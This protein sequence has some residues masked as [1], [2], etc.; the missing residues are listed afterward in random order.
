M[1]LGWWFPLFVPG[2][3]QAPGDPGL[4]GLVVAVAQPGEQGGVKSG[5]VLAAGGP[6]G[7]GC[8]AEGVAGLPGPGPGCRAGRVS[9]AGVPVQAGEALLDSGEPGVVAEV[10]AV[11]VADQDPAV[12]ARDPGPV[13]SGFVRLPAAPYQMR[14]A[15][16][17]V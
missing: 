10:A 11:V 16:P 7:G 15:P 5:L 2:A 12:A 3:G 1:S 14:S 6:D 9:I 8:R 13:I 17:P 4:D